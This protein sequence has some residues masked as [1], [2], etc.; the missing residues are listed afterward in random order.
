MVG[1]PRAVTEVLAGLGGTIFRVLTVI[2]A[3]FVPYVSFGTL[4][5]VSTLPADKRSDLVK[6]L[7]DW[8]RDRMFTLAK[9]VGAAA[10]TVL[11]ALIADD[12]EGNLKGGSVAL[13]LAGALVVGLLL[14]GGWIFASIRT[15]AEQLPA[16]EELVL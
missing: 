15:L 5:V 6:Q 12:T 10:V 16:A 3:L 2:R 7:F 8:E 11:V 9:G 1:A 4:L 13:D 14:L